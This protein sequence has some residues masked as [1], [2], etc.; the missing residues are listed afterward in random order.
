MSRGSLRQ[1]AGIQCCPLSGFDLET[2][3]L[4]DNQLTEFPDLA[5][6]PASVETIASSFRLPGRHP[7]RFRGPLPGRLAV[8]S[9]CRR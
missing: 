2:I 6:L 8:S 9:A 5:L 7:R 1:E 4:T 3:D